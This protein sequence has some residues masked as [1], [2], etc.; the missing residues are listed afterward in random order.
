[1][2]TRNASRS[3]SPYVDALCDPQCDQSS[4]PC[5]QSSTKDTQIE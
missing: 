3:S 5:D 2:E 1:M 4:T